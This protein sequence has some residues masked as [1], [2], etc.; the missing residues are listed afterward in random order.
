VAIIALLRMYGFTNQPSYFEM[1]E[2]SLQVFAAVAEQYGIFAAT[3]GIASA[4]FSQPHTQVIVVG[5]G[6]AADSL[7]AAA[8]A[9]F[10]LNKTVI[11]LTENEL[12]PQNLP[13]A[14]AATISSFSPP[15]DGTAVALICSGFTCQA[16]VGDAA[17]LTTA[18]R[19]QLIAA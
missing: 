10:A 18:L 4:H 8:V 9:P 13:P 3:Y 16:P 15:A 14:L 7:C 5:S 2:K 17:Q 1:A 12:T 6:E 19:N 11:R